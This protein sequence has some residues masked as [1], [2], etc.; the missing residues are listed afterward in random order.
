[1]PPLR[2]IGNHGPKP[3]NANADEDQDA[4]ERRLGHKAKAA[5]ANA[6]AATIRTTATRPVAW[7]RPPDWAAMAVRGGLESTAKAPITPASRLPAPTPM[8]S[9]LTSSSRSGSEGKPRTTAADCIMQTSATVS[10]RGSRRR[11]VCGSSAGSETVGS[12]NASAPRTPTP[13]AGKIEEPDRKGGREKPDQRAGDLGRDP[14]GRQG[15]GQ[16]ADADGER[17]GVGLRNLAEGIDQAG[18]QIGTHHAYAED[19]RKLAS[20]DVDRDAGEEA[21]GY[22][23]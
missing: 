15:E 23:D 9:R 4:A 6:T 13:R 18:D 21:G 8:K 22:R 2:A 1:M 20:D 16:H 11:S 5:P 3:E 12:V 7:E 10:A 19:R 14:F 17:Q